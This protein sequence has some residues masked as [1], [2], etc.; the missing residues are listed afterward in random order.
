M[1]NRFDKEETKC[2]ETLTRV[3]REWHGLAVIDL[4]NTIGIVGLVNGVRFEIV[5]GNENVISI[6]VDDGIWEIRSADTWIVY[7]T[8]GT[9]GS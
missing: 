4:I 5:I 9:I 6:R 8:Q 2:F 7:Q 3:F 1:K